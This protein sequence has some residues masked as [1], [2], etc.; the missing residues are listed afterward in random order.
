MTKINRCRGLPASSN[1]AWEGRHRHRNFS[2]LEARREPVACADPQVEDTRGTS[3]DP[4]SARS[5]EG[6]RAGALHRLVRSNPPGTAC[7][8]ALVP[9]AGPRHLR[10]RTN[11]PPRC[12]CLPA[13][14][15]SSDG[16]GLKTKRMLAAGVRPAG[17]PAHRFV[18]SRMA[19]RVFTSR[20]PKEST[21]AVRGV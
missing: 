13:C 3:T 16:E 1:R 20:I 17:R 19:L 8:G 4:L 6:L 21:G 15:V 10:R 11:L 2:L 12:C 5:Q 18:N 9:P 7:L 14:R